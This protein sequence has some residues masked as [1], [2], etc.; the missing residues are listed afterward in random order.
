MKPQLRIVRPVSSLELSIAMYRDG[1]GLH[2]IER[3]A[4]RQ[5]F[6]AALLGFPGLP[7]HF[8]LTYCRDQ[9]LVP[10]P[11]ADD[12]TVF[13]VPDLVEWQRLSAAMLAAGFT[14]VSSFN[15][16]WQRQGR[17]FADRDGYRVVLQQASWGAQ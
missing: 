1:L 6:D 7:Y 13:Y 16:Y 9:P 4:D 17:T 2:E 10:T 12:L 8:A 14:E 11:T 15:P 3:F 5:G